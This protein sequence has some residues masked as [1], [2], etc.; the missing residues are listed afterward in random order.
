MRNSV[1]SR[2]VA[3]FVRLSMLAS[4]VT[5]SAE[6][7]DEPGRDGL[8]EL[9]KETSVPTTEVTVPP[10]PSEFSVKNAPVV[11]ATWPDAGASEVTIPKS[12]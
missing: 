12:S 7:P 10:L 2:A 5:A 1:R 6:P 8:P 4:A 3:V 11:K 9:Q